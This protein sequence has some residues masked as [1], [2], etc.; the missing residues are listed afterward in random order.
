MLLP[1]RT[2]SRIEVDVVATPVARFVRH[3]STHQYRAGE[4]WVKLLLTSKI[5]CGCRQIP[6][7][8]NTTE[9]EGLRRA[10]SLEYLLKLIIASCSRR[11]GLYSVKLRIYL[12]VI[13]LGHY[14]RLLRENV[15]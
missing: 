5:R 4:R 11:R 3:P 8:R 15:H 14:A 2:S 1:T 9:E 12:R 10:I 6:A 7:A 13:C